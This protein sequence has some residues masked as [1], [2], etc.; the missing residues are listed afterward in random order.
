VSYPTGTETGKKGGDV[1]GVRD[2]E[3]AVGAVVGKCE[4]KKRRSDGMSFYMV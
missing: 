1:V 3:C 4:A 2:R